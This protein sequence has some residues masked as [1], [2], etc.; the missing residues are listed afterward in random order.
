MTSPPPFFSE[1]THRDVCVWEEQ[2]YRQAMHLLHGHATAEHGGDG[3]VSSVSRVTRRHH[4]FRVE[5]L[6]DELWNRQRSVLLTATRRQ[7][8]KAGHE[9]VQA[10]ERHH[11]DGQLAQVGV[12]L[13]TTSKRD[14]EYSVSQ[15]RMNQGHPWMVL[16]WIGSD[17]IHEFMDWIGSAKT[18]PRRTLV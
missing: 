2:M 10:R 17:W 12:Q 9:E 4:V 8:R 6:L 5:H 15:P 16:C 14:D 18:D 11:V 1:S 7:R 3:E 13:S